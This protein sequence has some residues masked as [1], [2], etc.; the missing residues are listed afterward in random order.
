MATD[1]KI[2]EALKSAATYLENSIRALD[3]KDGNSLM[4]SV[5]HLAA[6]LEYA[7]FMFSMALEEEKNKLKWRSN[8]RLKKAEVS[9]TLVAVQDLLKEVDKHMKERNLLEAYKKTDLARRYVLKVQRDFNRKKRE[10]F[11]AKDARKAKIKTTPPRKP[12][13]P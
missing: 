3:K 12:S 2:S 13:S 10:A 8:P 11:K 5:W 1:Q 9:S 4:D 7:L 6:E